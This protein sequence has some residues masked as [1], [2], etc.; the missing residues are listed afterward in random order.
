MYMVFA[1]QIGNP[2]VK[3][4]VVSEDRKISEAIESIF[5]MNTEDM[6]MIWNNIRIPL[7]YKY[8][9]SYMIDDILLM[10]NRIT[11]EDSGCLSIHW[12]PDVFRC[13]WNVKWNEDK[14]F[15]ESQWENVIG[16]LELL[17]NRCNRLEMNKKAFV[18]EWK[19]LLRLLC[20]KLLGCGYSDTILIDMNK[21]IEQE[22]AID[23]PGVL[24][25]QYN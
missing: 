11:S 15:V 5:L 21:L 12:L 1:I 8:E 13:N 7:S 18:S 20:D 4:K 23:T 3:S 19:S 9:I 2:Q 24:Y 16:H 14:V 25:K 22:K 17:L 10:L 6:I